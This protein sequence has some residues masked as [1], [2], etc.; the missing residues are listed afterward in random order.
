MRLH[1]HSVHLE[2]GCCREMRRCSDGNNNNPHS[3]YHGKSFN[4]TETTAH[5]MLSYGRDNVDLLQANNAQVAPIRSKMVTH[6]QPVR[7]FRNHVAFHYCRRHRFF[8]ASHLGLFS[9]I[10]FVWWWHLLVEACAGLRSLR[11]LHTSP[12][13]CR[14]NWLDCLMCAKWVPKRTYAIKQTNTYLLNACQKHA[15]KSP[16]TAKRVHYFACL[17]IYICICV[18]TPAS[19]SRTYKQNA[20]I[21]NEWMKSFWWKSNVCAPPCARRLPGVSVSVHITLSLTTT[22]SHHINLLYLF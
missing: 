6:T 10:N 8:S 21:S 7:A 16:F 17:Y 18:R 12:V 14:I 2:S 11:D 4:E 13:Y 5:V 19:I 15:L 3:Q 1:Y 9:R 22:S 20:P